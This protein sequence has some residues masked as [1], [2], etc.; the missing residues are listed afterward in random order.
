M[1][2][3]A[4]VDQKNFLFKPQQKTLPPCNQFST[5]KKMFNRGYIDKALF[6]ELH[7]HIKKKKKN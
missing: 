5:R 4:K 6:F 7:F 2:K 3:S 1:N